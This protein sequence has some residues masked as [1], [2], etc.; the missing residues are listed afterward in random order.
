MTD[1]HQTVE[2]AAREWFASADIQPVDVEDNPNKRAMFFVRYE[3]GIG[4]EFHLEPDG[5]RYRVSPIGDFMTPFDATDATDWFGPLDAHEVLD[6]AAQKMRR[7][8]EAARSRLGDVS[9]ELDTD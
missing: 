4:A 8:V 5:W 2:E 7:P 3:I 9:G 1:E 6:D